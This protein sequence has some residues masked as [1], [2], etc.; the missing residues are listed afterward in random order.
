MRLLDTAN[1]AGFFPTPDDVS[2]KFDVEA[3]SLS[4]LRLKAPES[5]DRASVMGHF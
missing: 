1:E 5:L 4:I 3:R 2:G